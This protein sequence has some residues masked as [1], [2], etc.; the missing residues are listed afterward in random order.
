MKCKLDNL[1]LTVLGLKTIYFNKKSCLIWSL[2]LPHTTVSKLFK[3]YD[4]LI[5]L[6]SADILSYK[7]WYVHITKKL[8]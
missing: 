2:K 8:P 3:Q 7:F 6:L 1:K 4:W 5:W